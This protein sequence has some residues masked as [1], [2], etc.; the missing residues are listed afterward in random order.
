MSIKPN[1]TAEHE[2]TC[3]EC[4]NL[5]DNPPGRP[6]I[7]P[8]P[9]LGW[10]QKLR[11]WHVPET[12]VSAAWAMGSSS[13]EQCRHF[14]HKPPGSSPGPRCSKR[15]EGRTGERDKYL[16]GEESDHLARLAVL[17]LKLSQLR[18]VLGVI[19]SSGDS[20]FARD[21]A[22]AALKAFSS[23]SDGEQTSQVSGYLTRLRERCELAEAETTRIGRE[24]LR[25]R[26]QPT[27]R[28]QLAMHALASG[29]TGAQAYAAA[30]EALKAR[31]QQ[32][33]ESK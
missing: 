6:V 19:S 14:T 9:S 29:K 26:E 28:D 12:P 22:G 11:R 2:P 3:G 8:H 33:A 20:V 13:P 16:T 30:D 18:E 4:V 23:D 7:P 10:C 31:N 24:L 17:G 5:L 15:P 21:L 32:P 1:Q 27:L 25:L